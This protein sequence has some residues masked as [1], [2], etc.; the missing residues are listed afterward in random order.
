MAR[1]HFTAMS[2]ISEKHM[3][4]KTK[5]SWNSSNTSPSCLLLIWHWLS[6]SLYKITE[7]HLTM[8]VAYQTDIMCV[9]E[10]REFHEGCVQESLWGGHSR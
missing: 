10:H 5:N 6:L 7:L 2:R 1:V 8:Y 4:V 9:A 3:N